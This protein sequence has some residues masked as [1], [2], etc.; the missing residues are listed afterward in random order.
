MNQAKHVK[1]CG[2]G[3]SWAFIGSFFVVPMSSSLEETSELSKN[4]SKSVVLLTDEQKERMRKNRERALELQ[5]RKN[6]ERLDEV[7]NEE[8]SRAAKKL[9]TTTDKDGVLEEFE[10]GASEYVTK[11][12]AMKI[13]C[14]PEGTLAVCKFMEKENPRH[15]GWT[16]MKMYCREEIRRR[17]RERFGGLDGL[18]EERRKREEK[19]FQK[20]LELTKHVF[21]K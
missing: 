16:P 20:D 15:P 4:N 12:E 10:V 17:A 14:L 11:R 2:S 19:R 21:R 8:S 13:Y 6:V 5:K 9:K 1:S 7:K 3:D 18:I